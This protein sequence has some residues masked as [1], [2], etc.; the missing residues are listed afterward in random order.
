MSRSFCKCLKHVPAWIFNGP[1]I[2]SALVCSV[3]MSAN[4]LAAEPDDVRKAVEKSLPFLWKEGNHWIEKRGCVS[5][6]QVPFMVWSLNSASRHDFEVDED[7]LRKLNEWANQISHFA[8]PKNDSDRVESEQAKANLDTMA[9]LLLASES[10]PEPMQNPL[11]V[12]S[13][14]NYLIE[15]QDPDGTWNPCGQ[16]IFQKRS[17]QETRE[18]STLWNLIALKADQ[19]ATSL[20]VPSEKILE[21]FSP[22]GESTEWWAA[23]L[24]WSQR[25]GN[26]A[27][28]EA[29]AE[30]LIDFQHED[31]GW[32]WIT[33]DESDAFGTSVALYALQK[34]D[35]AFHKEQQ[36]AAI[37]YLLKNQAADGSWPVKS[38][39]AKNA[40]QITPT[41]TYWG[42][43]WSVIALLDSLDVKY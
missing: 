8:N 1:L 22:E 34:F 20:S 9:Q 4:A 24:L 30:R 23:K 11:A 38:T 7:E 10:A 13:F 16:L 42:T 29:L 39:K 6:H 14:R 12:E 41:A 21:Q 17:K 32:G 40:T 3:V 19:P 15:F 25:S 36:L 37:D 27:Q 2:V 18:A 33:A 35:P 26:Q 5:C 43:A 28:A 31:G